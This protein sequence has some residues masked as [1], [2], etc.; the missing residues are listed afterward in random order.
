MFSSF[1]ILICLYALLL[2][3]ILSH[4]LM[5]VFI[6][7]FYAYGSFKYLLQCFFSTHVFLAFI[8]PGGLFLLELW[9][10]VLMNTT[11]Q[12]DNH[13]FSGL[14]VQ[15]SM[16]SSFLEFMPLNMLLFWWV[17]FYM[18]L[19]TS[20]LQFSIVFPFSVHFMLK[21]QY[22]VRIF[23][24]GFSVSCFESFLYLNGH[25]FPNNWGY[26]AII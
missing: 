5:A 9:R 10:I 14:K 23:F 15:R 19:D 24:S 17:F 8:Y 13:F 25:L 4:M 2:R 7:L 16:L 22:N 20:L 6:F 12:I 21:I 18:W 1:L 3:F 11:I 26:F